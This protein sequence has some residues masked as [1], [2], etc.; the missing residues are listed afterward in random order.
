MSWIITYDHLEDR[1][2]LLNKPTDA[3]VLPKYKYA[4]RLF[5]DD[6]ELYFSGLATTRDD[7]AAF[8]PLDATMGSYGCTEIQYRQDDDTWETL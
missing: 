4:F 6:G 2:V 3:R 5:D 8:E 1:P 7:E